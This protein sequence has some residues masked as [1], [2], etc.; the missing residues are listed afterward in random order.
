M[1]RIILIPFHFYLE[2]TCFPICRACFLFSNH[3]SSLNSYSISSSPSLTSLSLSSTYFFFFFFFTFYFITR[4]IFPFS[5]SSIHYLSIPFYS[6]LLNC[7]R[8]IFPPPAGSCLS[9]P[10]SICAH[11]HIRKVCCI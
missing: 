6:C 4:I 8:E 9:P 1:C 5:S 3:Q 11:F 10:L 7:L 2:S